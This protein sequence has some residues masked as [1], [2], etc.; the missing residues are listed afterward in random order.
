MNNSQVLLVEDNPEDIILTQRAFQ[1]GNL[2]YDLVVAHD[3]L[4]ALDYLFGWNSSNKNS[5]IRPMLILLDLKLPKIDGFEVLEQIRKNP[6]TIL[7]P[8]VILSTS[9]EYRDIEKSYR[10][11]AN[12]YIQKAVDCCEFTHEIC[13]VLRFW[14]NYQN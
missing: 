4:E 14:A 9:L 12:C 10:L 5:D 3:G 8:V 13:Q 11:G 1:K 7:L 2:P 6:N